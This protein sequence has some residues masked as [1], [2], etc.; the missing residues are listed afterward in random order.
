[1]HKYVSLDYGDHVESRWSSRERNVRS[2]LPPHN[3][4]MQPSGKN[5]MLGRG[6]VSDVHELVQ[7]ARVLNRP[8]AVPER[9]V[10]RHD[11]F[12]TLIKILRR[13]MEES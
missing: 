3:N 13:T 11:T 9:N 6:R 1:V 4:P 10:R 5:G 12:A 8:R 2:R 7:L